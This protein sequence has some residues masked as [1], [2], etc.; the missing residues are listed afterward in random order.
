MKCSGYGIRL[1]V[2]YSVTFSDMNI[3]AISHSGCCKLELAVILKDS[4]ELFEHV[5]LAGSDTLYLKMTM[6]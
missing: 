1:S 4:T 2:V 6:M 3:G 5:S